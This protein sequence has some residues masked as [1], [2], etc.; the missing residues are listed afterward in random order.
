MIEE[1][2]ALLPNLQLVP[3]AEQRY[4][5]NVSFCGPRSLWLANHSPDPDR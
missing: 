2:T 4:I 3:G 1:L 5:D